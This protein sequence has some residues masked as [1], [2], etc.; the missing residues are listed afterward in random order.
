M[1][2]VPFDTIAEFM[3]K[4]TNSLYEIFG[5]IKMVRVLRLNK[6]IQFL[7]VNE[8]LKAS[9]KLIKMIGFL[10]I[11]IHIFSCIWWLMV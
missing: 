9:M 10:V 4:E 6:V 8:D 1:A 7:R 3:F 2:T 5:I 11:Y